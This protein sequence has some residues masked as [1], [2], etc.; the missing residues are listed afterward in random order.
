MTQQ[1]NETLQSS[2]RAQPVYVHHYLPFTSTL[3]PPSAENLTTDRQH[4]PQNP[5]IIIRSQRHFKIVSSADSITATSQRQRFEEMQ[6]DVVDPRRRLVVGMAV[7][8]ASHERNERVST[9]DEL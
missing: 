6:G 9:T 4:S 2:P 3:H 5:I 1:V 7:T 8:K